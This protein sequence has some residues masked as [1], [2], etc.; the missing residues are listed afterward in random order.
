MEFMQDIGSALGYAII[1][2]GLS[3]YHTYRIMTNTEINGVKIN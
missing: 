3:S 1:D 2:R